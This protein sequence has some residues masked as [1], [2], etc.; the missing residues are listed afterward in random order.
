MTTELLRPGEVVWYV[1]YQEEQRRRLGTVT[2]WVSSRPDC[3]WVMLQDGSIFL[4]H[5]TALQR[6][7][8][9]AG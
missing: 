4:Y 9:M 8:R 1:P 6:V 7:C 3:C 2:N 5:R